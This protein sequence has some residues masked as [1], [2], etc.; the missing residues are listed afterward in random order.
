[1]FPSVFLSA[2][3]WGKDGHPHSTD[4][5]PEE[6]RGLNELPEATLQLGDRTGLFTQSFYCKTLCFA[7]CVPDAFSCKFH[8]MLLIA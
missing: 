2:A 3:P 1:M 8:L 5:E 4:K 6:E 7:F